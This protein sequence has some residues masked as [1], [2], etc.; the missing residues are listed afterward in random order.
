MRQMVQGAYIAIN[1]DVN[2]LKEI[3]LVLN[4][5]FDHFAVI[6]C[7]YY[8]NLNVFRVAFWLFIDGDII[9]QEM[10]LSLCLAEML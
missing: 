3:L 2:I 9:P 7:F 1:D 10:F 4:L 5:E 6:W 8:S